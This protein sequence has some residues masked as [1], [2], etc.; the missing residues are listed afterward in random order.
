[1]NDTRKPEFEYEEKGDGTYAVSV[2][3]AA[4]HLIFPAEHCGKRITELASGYE[5]PKNRN[6]VEWV[7]V[8]YGI[9][10]IGYQSLFDLH[11][12]K[13]VDLPQSVTE[14]EDLAFG[15]CVSLPQITLPSNVK[16]IGLGAFQHCKKLEHITLPLA[17]EEIGKQAFSNCESLKDLYIPQSVKKI[18]LWALEGCKALEKITVDERNTAF[19]SI[20][21]VLYSGDKTVLIRYPV[22]RRETAFTVPEGVTEIADS[23]FLAAPYLETVHLP[24]T[25][26]VIGD[27]AFCGCNSLTEIPIPQSVRSIGEDAFYNCPLSKN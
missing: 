8:P 20:D 18:G 27:A 9:E 3:S 17:L 15:L 11:A 6:V 26:T 25:L 16:K 10:I 13:R 24:S 12:L 5:I 22:G 21:G 19:C 1:M 23:A 2:L 7:T 4:S 14:I